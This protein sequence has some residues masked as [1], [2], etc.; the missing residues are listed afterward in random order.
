ERDL[1]SFDETLRRIR[2][3]EGINFTETNI[4][5]KTSKVA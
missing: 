3:I 4:L 5:L 1:A 2:L